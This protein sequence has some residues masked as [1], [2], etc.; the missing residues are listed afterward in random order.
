MKAE[1]QQEHRWLE[2]LVG[3]WTYQ[4]EAL[5][6]PDQPPIKSQ[7]TETVRS[8]GAVWVQCEGKGEMPGGGPTTTL[9][10]LGYDTA[11][12]RFV[13]TFI[14]SMMTYL[15]VYEGELD[16]SGK[17][18]ILSAEGPAWTVE[19]KMARYHDIIEFVSDDHR[20]LTSQQ[21]G[22][23]GQWK[24]FMVAHYRRKKA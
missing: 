6:G 7:G 13:G 19:G 4:S 10:T 22:D 23:D 20:T 16:P 12:K 11:K 24:E 17:K 14:G 5:M 8:I 3:E 1:P 15:W 21:L 18:L 2:R 9:I